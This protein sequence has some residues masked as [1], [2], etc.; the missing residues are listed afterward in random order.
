MKKVIIYLIVFIGILTPAAAQERSAIFGSISKNYPEA[1]RYGMVVSQHH[2]ASQVGADILAKGGNAVDAAVATGFAMAVVLPKAGNIGGGGFMLVYLAEE[3]KTIAIDYR[4]MAPALANIDM[5]LDEDGNVKRKEMLTQKAAGVPGT[6]AGFYFAHAK[7]GKLSWAEV[8]GP[9]IHLAE[10]G[11]MV[12]LNLAKELEQNIRRLGRTKGSIDLFY[13]GGGNPYQAGEIFKMPDLARVLKLIAEK[14]PDGFYKG[15]V[16]DLIVA[17]MERSNGIITHEDLASYE[18]LVREPVKSTYKGH[19]VVSMPPPSSGGIHII[20]IL[21][22]L[23]NFDLKTMGP[24]SAGTLSTMAEA[25]KYAYADR[26]EHLGDPDRY[27]VPVEWLTSKE[28]G[29]EI[30]AKIKENGVQPSSAIKPG[31]APAYESPDT[32]HISVADKWGNVV[33][34]TYTINYSYG[35]GIVVEGAGFLLNNEMD[36]F[37]AKPGAPNAYGL[38]GDEANAISPGKRP[39]SSMSPVIVFKDGKP[40]F[41]SGSPGGSLIISAVVQSLVN[42]LEFNMGVGDAVAQTRIHHQWLPDVLQIEPGFNPDTYEKL[43]AMGYD[44]RI[45]TYLT[46]VEALQIDDQGW[47]Y[48]FADRRR[49]DGGAVGLCAENIA[50]AC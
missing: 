34:N 31:E 37:S 13:R 49:A 44:I 45:A 21:N 7:Y 22:I 47:M 33:S 20:Q 30:A 6:V 28:Y 29:A 36:D 23:D 24:G 32:T 10:E 48:G 50:R 39:L 16:A 19:D 43:K 12:S 15:E 27:D 8:L 11:F 14:G 46:A 42:Y 17:E 18:V 35:S 3:E 4:E 41:I 38:I 5:Y 25:M 1:G 40:V 26:S 9:A 2:L